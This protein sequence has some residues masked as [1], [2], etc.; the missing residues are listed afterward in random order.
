MSRRRRDPDSQRFLRI[1]ALVFVGVLILS[2]LL[3]TCGPT[4]A[5]APTGV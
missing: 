2:L 4:P 3:Q 5:V 1:A